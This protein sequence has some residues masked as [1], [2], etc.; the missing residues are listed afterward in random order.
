MLLQVVF[1]D[2]ECGAV[3]TAAQTLCMALNHRDS[4]CA[5]DSICAASK[6]LDCD[7]PLH[8]KRRVTAVS[9]VGML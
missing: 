5:E 3:A 1:V 9:A 4:I 8:K 7:T 6:P 2:R